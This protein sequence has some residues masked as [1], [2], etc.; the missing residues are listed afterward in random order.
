[1]HGNPVKYM[2]GHLHFGYSYV[3]NV[4]DHTCGN[5]G[6]LPVLWAEEAEEQQLAWQELE[7][8]VRLKVKWA[9]CVG[10]CCSSLS[11]APLMSAIPVTMVTNVF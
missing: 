3:Y 8:H 5:H 1:M 11:S 6:N 10:L 7:L 2:S 4:K 9:F